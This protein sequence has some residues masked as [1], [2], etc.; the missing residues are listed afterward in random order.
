MT[1]YFTIVAALAAAAGVSVAVFALHASNRSALAA[2]NSAKYADQ[3][4][5]EAKRQS[6]AAEKA[7]EQN[8]RL[9]QLQ[10]R[11]YLSVGQVEVV[12]TAD[13]SMLEFSVHLANSGQSP[14]LS[15]I[16]DARVRLTKPW[17][18]VSVEILR[19]QQTAPWSDVASSSGSNTSQIVAVFPDQLIPAPF[20]TKPEFVIEQLDAGLSAVRVLVKFIVTYRDVFGDQ[21]EH[22]A[23]YEHP[24]IGRN[25]LGRTIPMYRERTQVFE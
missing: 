5:E 12:A 10:V 7:L 14:A 19:R 2:E 3:A 9:G 25:E 16:C 17:P 20:A 22:V 21:H 15:V 24:R 13:N 11:A 1:D 18:D 8:Q 6:D 23:V 4:V